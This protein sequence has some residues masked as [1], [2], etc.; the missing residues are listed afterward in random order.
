MQ[1]KRRLAIAEY[2][3]GWDG[4]QIVGER[5]ERDTM[6]C[7]VTFTTVRAVAVEIAEQLVAE[8][9]HVVRGT[10]TLKRD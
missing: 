7:Y 9:P 5:R 1:A 4:V 6:R 10:F 3:D 2:L 8:C